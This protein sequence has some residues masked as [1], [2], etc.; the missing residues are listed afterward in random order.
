MILLLFSIWLL[1]ILG[2]SFWNLKWGVVLFLLYMVLVPYVKLRFGGIELGQNL[3]N[4]AFLV[5]YFVYVKKYRVRT[6]WKPLLPF[7][8]YFAAILFIMPFQT[9]VPLE[10]M[11]NSWRLNIM[12]TL[13]LP[14]VMWNVAKHEPSSIS[15]FRNTIFVSILVAVGYGLFLTTTGGVNPYIMFFR[16]SLNFDDYYIDYYAADG[17]GRLFGRISS[18]FVHPMTY[19]LFLGL[20]FIYVFQSRHV[21]NKYLTSILLV[22]V[23]ISMITC[24]V[25][26]VLGGMVAAITCYF[27]MSKNYKMMLGIIVIAFAGSIL[28]DSLP[29][30]SAYLGSITDIHNKKGAVGGS[31]IEMRLSQLEGS[32]NEASSL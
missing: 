10:V 31:N 1:L 19:A 18:V 8:I 13:F 9:H 24:G 22:A 29:E 3:F 26:S 5:S 27:L 4:F 21:I 25:R 17:G 20:S 15:L 30:L 12:G 11:L 23:G 7:V 32:I 14:F 2:L 16:T 28:I 6:D